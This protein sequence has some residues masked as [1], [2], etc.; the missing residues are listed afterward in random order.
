MNTATVA[1]APRLQPDHR[2]TAILT[3]AV[4]V[5]TNH[6]WSKFTRGQV[7]VAARVSPALVT[8]YYPADDLRAAVMKH[9]IDHRVLRIVAEGVT[10]RDPQALAADPALRADAMKWVAENH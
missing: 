9:A 2:A 6:G 5:A 3:T 1:R 10:V 7:A 8:H 4:Q